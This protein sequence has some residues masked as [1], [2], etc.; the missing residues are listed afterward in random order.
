MLNQKKKTCEMFYNTIYEDYKWS[1]NKHWCFH[2]IKY[3]LRKDSKISS[4]TSFAIV[5]WVYDVVYKI[6]YDV[7]WAWSNFGQIFFKW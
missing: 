1:I 6:I 2:S 4:I 3:L 5:N 7:F